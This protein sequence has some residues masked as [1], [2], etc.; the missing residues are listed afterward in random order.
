ML[1]TLELH[2]L[3]LDFL[4][5]HSAQALLPCVLVRKSFDQLFWTASRTSGTGPRISGWQDSLQQAQFTSA[6]KCTR[7][8]QLQTFRVYR[9]WIRLVMARDASWLSGIRT[10]IVGFIVA[11]GHLDKIDRI[12]AKANKLPLAPLLWHNSFM[13]RVFT[14]AAEGILHSSIFQSFSRGPITTCN[15]MMWGRLTNIATRTRLLFPSRNLDGSQ[16]SNSVSD[17]INSSSLRRSFGRLWRRLRE[18]C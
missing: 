9:Q 4:V 1:G 16:A 12:G 14:R 17:E 3:D 11:G 7:G 15:S 2:L 5:Q 8:V 18:R 6:G 10:H 13:L